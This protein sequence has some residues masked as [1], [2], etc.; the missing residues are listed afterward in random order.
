MSVF[1]LV[2]D[3][4]NKKLLYEFRENRMRTVS[5][6]VVTSQIALKLRKMTKSGAVTQE[7]MG[8]KWRFSNSSET[9]LIWSFCM[10]F[11][12]FGWKLT[13]EKRNIWQAVAWWPSRLSMNIFIH[14]SG[15]WLAGKQLLSQSETSDIDL[16]CPNDTKWDWC[17]WPLNI[18]L[19]KHYTK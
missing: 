9:L 10:S 6:R 2:R 18:C 13:E 3:L 16:L 14:G 15:R 5:S 4:I 7:R 12:K 8:E 17:Q 1:E 19:T 11:V